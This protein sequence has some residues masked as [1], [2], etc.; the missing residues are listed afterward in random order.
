MLTKDGKNVP[1]EE[2]TPENYL[3]K[4]N[5]KNTYHIRLEVVQFNPK[6]GVRMSRPRIQKIGR[7]TFRKVY[8]S[9]LKQGY[10][11]EVLYSPEEW[12][13]RKAAELAQ[14]KEARKPLTQADFDA[15][16]AKAVAD[17]LANMQKAEEPE[18]KETEPEGKEKTKSNKK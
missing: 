17:A 9:L 1:I 11:I 4:E 8:D 7:K 3:V 18:G 2:L 12:F 6:T 13:A 15:A 5:E 10:K 16:V 14:K